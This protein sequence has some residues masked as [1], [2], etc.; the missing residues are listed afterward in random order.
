MEIIPKID[1]I[2]PRLAEFATACG[3]ALA[4]AH[5][6]IGDPVAIDAYI[7]MDNAF[8]AGIGEFAWRY[9]EQNARDHAAFTEAIASG[10]H[11][12]P[13]NIKR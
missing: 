3:N 5:A 13:V 4:R 6:R 9:A 7:G 12:A 1:L 10:R 8:N 2:A 11:P